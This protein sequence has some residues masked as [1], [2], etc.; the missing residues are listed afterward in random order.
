[1]G[2]TLLVA[3][4]MVLAV[5]ARPGSPAWTHARP[6]S[7]H[8]ARLMQLATERSAVVRALL[9]DLE[10]TDV[11][12]YL[13]FSQDAVPSHRRDS[14]C[15]LTDAGGTRYVVITIHWRPEPPIAYVPVLAHE[16]QH[17]LELAGAAGVRDSTALARLYRTI[18]WQ[19]ETGAFESDRARAVESMARQE[20]GRSAG[21]R[22]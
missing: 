4:S 16:L 12:A 14:M 17:A 10:R 13:V 2:V 1:M 15:F 11:V 9:D 19:T 8:A 21:S 5:G 7:P 3:V 6:T 20:L 22:Q 18:G